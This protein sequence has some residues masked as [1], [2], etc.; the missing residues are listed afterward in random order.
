MRWVWA[1]WDKPHRCPECHRIN[2]DGSETGAQPLPRCDDCQ[3]R[4]SFLQARL[5]LRWWRLATRL[6]LPIVLR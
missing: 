4:W 6:Q 1:N 2:Y 5:R 3:V